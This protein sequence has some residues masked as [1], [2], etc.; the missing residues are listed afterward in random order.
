MSRFC[1]LGG[2]SWGLTLANHLAGKGH[3]VTVWVRRPEKARSLSINRSDPQRLPG[4]ELSPEIRFTSDMSEALDGAELLLF[5][6]PSQAMREVARKVANVGRFPKR[7]VSATKGIEI[8]TGMRMSQ[9]IR[10]ELGDVEVAVISGPS[11][12]LEVARGLPTS[13]VA[14]SENQDYAREVQML[15]HSPT[16]RVYTSD[17]VIGVELGG[18]LKNIV[19]IAAGISDGLGFGANTKGALLTRGL[20]EIM[21]LGIHLGARPVTF[22]GLSGMGD[23]ITTSFSKHSRNRYVGEELGK[24]RSIDEILS[25][26][27]MVAEGVPTAEAVHRL[28]GRIGVDMPLTEAVLM[29]IRGEWTPQEAI[30][31]LTQREPKPEYYLKWTGL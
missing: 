31:R 4:I 18:A 2:G 11:I 21:R 29:I 6:V 1:V 23:L 9:V 5:V 10:E 27:T 7:I 17:D 19:A 28:A 16:F 3:H 12:A 30:H 24:G 20:A 25:G 13:V 14:A 26:M 15:F 22:A 8:E